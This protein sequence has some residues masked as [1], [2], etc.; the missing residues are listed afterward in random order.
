[1]EVAVT[2]EELAQLKAHNLHIR[3]AKHSLL[4]SSAAADKY[5]NPEQVIQALGNI[6]A[7]YPS[8]TRVFDGGK[9]HQQ[10]SIMAME[11]SAHPGDLDKPVVIFNAMHHAR[12]VM[13]TEVVMHI[14]KVLTENYGKSPEVTKWLDQYRIVLVPQ[15]N[16]DGNSFV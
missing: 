12:E 3:K 16:P 5:L 10:R 7:Q 14:A 2:Q 15:V 1:A 8:I 4:K 9:T 13:T 11:I 6:N